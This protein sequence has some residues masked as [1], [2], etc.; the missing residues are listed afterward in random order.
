MVPYDKYTVEES[1]D[2]YIHLL[3]Y[4]DRI[5]LHSPPEPRFCLYQV[6]V[7]FWYISQKTQI[8]Y[9]PCQMPPLGALVM[10][11]VN[12]YLLVFVPLCY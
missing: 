3:R 9:F 5:N 7:A 1:I 2:Y 6:G 11:A 12:A 10:I 4:P 8:I